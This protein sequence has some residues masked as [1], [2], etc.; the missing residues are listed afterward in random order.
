MKDHSQAPRT[1]QLGWDMDHMWLLRDMVW[2]LEGEWRSAD[3]RWMPLSGRVEVQDS[4]AK[5]ILDADD[6]PQRFLTIHPGG[7]NRRITRLEL[8]TESVTLSGTLRSF[9]FRQDLSATA[10]SWSLAETA[11]QRAD[12]SVEVDGIFTR[13][14][15]VRDAWRWILRPIP[16]PETWTIAPGV[17]EAI[18]SAASEGAPVEQCG[19]LVGRPSERLVTGQIRMAN[20]ENSIDR[21]AMDPQEQI[22]AAKSL[23]GTEEAIVGSWHS[24]PFSPARLSDEDLKQSTDESALY[25]IVSLMEKE[26]AF[27]LYKVAQGAALPVRTSPG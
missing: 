26:P 20:V 2:S 7:G 24:H 14:G 16:I 6:A 21:Y 17:V 12:G 27:R 19:L 18:G 8:Q 13:L 11:L 9:G 10:G 23:R 1:S 22:R 3:G 15:E 5:W 4:L 25:G